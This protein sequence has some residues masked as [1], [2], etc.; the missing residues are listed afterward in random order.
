M[1]LVVVVAVSAI[2]LGCAFACFC[3]CFGCCD[4]R[5]FGFWC[6]GFSEDFGLMIGQRGLSLT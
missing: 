1:T 2:G 5:V 4:D 3:E 6:G